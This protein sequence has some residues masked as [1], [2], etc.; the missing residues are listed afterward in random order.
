MGLGGCQVNCILPFDICSEEVD[1]YSPDSIREFCR[2]HDRAL[3]NGEHGPLRA[4]PATV[5]HG[6]VHDAALNVER[7]TFWAE[8]AIRTHLL[9]KPLQNQFI[10]TKHV[11]NLEQSQTFSVSFS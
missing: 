3:A 7:S 11:R 4:V 5:S 1:A 9:F 10:V 6:L 8:R 2:F